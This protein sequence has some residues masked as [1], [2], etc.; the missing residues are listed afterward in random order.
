MGNGRMRIVPGVVVCTLW[1][2]SD[3]LGYL[4]PGTGSFIF[5]AVIAVVCGAGLGIKMFWSRIRA[6]FSRKGK[7]DSDERSKP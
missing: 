6:A 5:Q 3:A 2:S 1:L 7:G 4:D